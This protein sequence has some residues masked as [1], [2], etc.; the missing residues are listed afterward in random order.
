MDLPPLSLEQLSKALSDAPTAEALYD[1]LSQYESEACLLFT[2]TQVTG[3]AKLLS[4]FY[5]SF[6]ISH[7]LTDQIQEARSLTQ[8][9]P[10]TLVKEDLVLQNSI[11]LLRAVWQNKHSEIYRILRE[12]P[13]PDPVNQIVQKYDAYFAEKT[14]KEISRAYEA[15]RPEKAAAYLGLENGQG[16]SSEPSP[17]L[18]QTLTQRGWVWDAN[19]HLFRPKVQDKPVELNG[20]RTN[21]ISEL[22]GLVSS[23][24]G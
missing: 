19:E 15:I 24:G 14:F 23:Y 20:T 8:R 4:A 11:T 9:M 3:D 6:L 22:V 10:P 7:L 2:D 5:A 21:G 13:W 1:V 17:A 12:L 18:I 16:D